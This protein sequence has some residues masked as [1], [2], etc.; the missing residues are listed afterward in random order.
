ME[1]DEEREKLE[2]F[3]MELREAL[4]RYKA[5]ELPPEERHPALPPWQT[6]TSPPGTVTIIFRNSPPPSPSPKPSA[7]E[8]PAP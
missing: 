7:E 4:E 2:R 3:R 8:P 1:H 5:G 6:V